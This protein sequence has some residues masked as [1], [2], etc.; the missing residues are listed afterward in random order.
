MPEYSPRAMRRDLLSDEEFPPKRLAF[1]MSDQAPYEHAAAAA[2]LKKSAD[3]IREHMAEYPDRNEAPLH[4]EL[5]LA[6]GHACAVAEEAF[7]AALKAAWQY[8]WLLLKCNCHSCR[9][10]RQRSNATFN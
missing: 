4:Q 5:E 8:Y 10:Q 7:E 1:H 9:I 3:R 6:V 2:E